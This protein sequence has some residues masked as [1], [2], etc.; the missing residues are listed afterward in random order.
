MEENYQK[1]NVVKI[2]DKNSFVYSSE[3]LF[4]LQRNDQVKFS[5]TDSHIQKA[6]EIKNLFGFFG[7]VLDSRNLVNTEIDKKNLVVNSVLKNFIKDIKDNHRKE[8]IKIADE[9]FK[10][11]LDETLRTLQINEKIVLSSLDS[12]L[13]N[14]MYIPQVV[15]AIG[16]LI[17][18]N[19]QRQN[20]SQLMQIKK[21]DEEIVNRSGRGII[22]RLNKLGLEKSEEVNESNIEVW[23]GDYVFILKRD[24]ISHIINNCFSTEDIVSVKKISLKTEIIDNYRNPRNAKLERLKLNTLELTKIPELFRFTEA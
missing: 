21:K 3:S 24:C 17:D 11:Y 4:V 14:M 23:E 12:H 15:D 8:E 16:I 2:A 7:V 5:F 9:D 20:T 18:R 1:T 19:Y 6:R 10:K 22:V 13:G